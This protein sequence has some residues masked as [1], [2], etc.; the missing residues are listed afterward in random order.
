MLDRRGFVAA[1]GAGLLVSTSLPAQA[2]SRLAPDNPKSLHS[3]FLRQLRA[4]FTAS[5][6]SAA[7]AMEL[8]AVETDDASTGLER[9]RLVFRAAT[10]VAQSGL[11][12]LKAER[13]PSLHQQVYLEPS[14][15]DRSGRCLTAQF[16]L[17][18]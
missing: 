2:L 9:F 7:M 13:D 8:I 10:P 12:K 15:Y 17:L 16:C 18:S 11:Y 14:E 5:G 4:R 3:A 6:E 1:G